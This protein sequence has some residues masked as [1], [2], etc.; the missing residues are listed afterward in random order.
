MSRKRFLGLSHYLVLAVVLVSLLT[1]LVPVSEVRADSVVIFPDP[2]LERAIR[3]ARSG[4]MLTGDI[5][6]SDLD[7]LTK[8]QFTSDDI[9]D[10]TGMEHCTNLTELRLVD[11]RIS[12]LSPLSGL[13]G[14]TGLWLPNNQIS[15]LSPLSGLTNL[16][17][18]HLGF[19][20]TSDLSPLSSLTNLTS[21]V[22][23]NNQISDLSP[24]SGL[25]NLELLQLDDNQI[26]DI[27]PLVNN[28]GLG[29]V[30]EVYLRRNPLSCDSINTSIPSLQAR[31][32]S[33]YWDTTSATIGGHIEDGY[34]H[35]LGGVEVTLIAV[36]SGS[37][38]TQEVTIADDDG[39]YSFGASLNPIQPGTYQIEVALECH[40]AVGDTA[41]FSVNHDMGS[42]VRA[43]TDTFDFDGTCGQGVK[44]ID[45]VDPYVHPATAVPADRLDD[46]AAM[47]YHTKQVVDFSQSE[48][49][50]TLDLSLPIV[51]HGYVPDDPSTQYNESEGAWYTAGDVYMGDSC[52][53]YS[54]PDRPMSQDWHEMFHELMDDTVGLPPYIH[55][56]DDYHGGYT[57]HCTGDSWVEGWAE[58]WPCSLKGYLGSASWRVYEWAGG[59]TNFDLN[60]MVWNSMEEFAVA[61]LL[62]DLIDPVDPADMDYVSVTTT[63]LWAIIGSK[64][65]A[66]MFEVYSALVTAKV[67]QTDYDADG[68]SD[69]DALFIAHGF[70]AD[71]GNGAYDGET[72]GLGG[73][74]GR[75]TT[76]KI[77]NA[78]LRILVADSQGN[79]ISG[80]TL[81][82]D[83]VFPSPR[84]IYNYGYEVSL[85]GSDSHVGFY[86]A[87][88]G[89]EAL[90]KMRVKDG[91]GTLSD[92][93]V[94]SNSV[95]WEK[96]SESTTG[97]AAEHTFVIGAEGKT[98]VVGASGTTSGGVPVWI[99]PVAAL[100]VIAAGAGGFFLFFLL[101]RRKAKR[102]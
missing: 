81:L 87:P 69:L 100:A 77:P 30:D 63:E 96:V 97:Y 10:L 61:G 76:P 14:L 74:P 36:S 54:H 59:K 88:D 18:L 51:V 86:V 40:E 7:R 84:D 56:G 8:I 92:E 9:V 80:G 11:N 71:D 13:T 17:I 42:S 12:D 82:V 91:D 37:P 49:G 95:Y 16:T 65:L 98:T 47:Y 26:S 34:D 58:F 32:V 83:V 55:T 89:Y 5:H 50:V 53:D 66:N 35:R 39:Q 99:W 90:M 48:L 43:Q 25:T 78:N 28:P 72:V 70:F 75:T 29:H 79:P 27:V 3:G 101:P 41:I 93:L 22:M 73:K 15:N 33:V 1:L 6:Q 85:S 67:G 94:V 46:L 31:G 68:I 24:L 38:T 102:S 23:Y 44:D 62:I 20:R 64:Q 60:M 4:P 57:N 21:L 2:N 19:N 45:F 52:S